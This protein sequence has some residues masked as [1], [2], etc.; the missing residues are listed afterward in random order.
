[1]LYKANQKDLNIWVGEDHT[2]P[3]GNYLTINLNA[4]IKF[5][6]FITEGTNV[7]I[8]AG[9]YKHPGAIHD[10]STNLPALVI[11]DI[12]LCSVTCVCFSKLVKGVVVVPI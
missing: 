7:G 5:Q 12:V 1:M 2:E 6:N 8:D 9:P 11:I 10:H 3:Q 4:A